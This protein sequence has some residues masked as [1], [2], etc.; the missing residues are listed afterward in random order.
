[1]RPSV[2]ATETKVEMAQ[3][4]QLKI[5]SGLEIYFC[6]PRSPWQRGTNEN[7]N[8]LL[9]QYFPEGT[10]LPATLA[11]T[12]KPSPWR[13]TPGH[14]RRS[15]GRHPPRPSINFY[16][17]TDI[18]TLR[19]PLEPGSTSRATTGSSSWTW[20]WSSRSGDFRLDQPLHGPGPSEQQVVVSGRKGGTTR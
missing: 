18:A 12:S 2:H 13:S 10:D 17:L 19:R 6:E 4:A 7:T 1:M 3:H 5:D 14:V 20:G 16:A 8:G 15:V 9:R 11:T